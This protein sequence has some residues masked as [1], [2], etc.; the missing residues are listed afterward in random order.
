MVKTEVDKCPIC[1]KNKPL[2]P[3]PIMGTIMKRG[4]FEEVSIDSLGPIT[5]DE[6]NPIKYI[7][8]IID[9]FSRFVELIPSES[10]TAKEAVD[11]L[12]Q[13]V[14]ARHGVPLCIRSDAG[15]QYNNALTAEL[16]KRLNIES[17]ITTP[18]HHQENGIV[19]RVN[20]E[21]WKHLRTAFTK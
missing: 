20:R 12:L 3:P 6:E 14:I 15:R 10:T 9:N 4:I 18:G 17:V 16:Y 11:A 1:Q 5:T 7:I 19:E 13:G 21:I 2:P 8:V